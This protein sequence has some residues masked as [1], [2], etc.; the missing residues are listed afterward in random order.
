MDPAVASRK[1]INASN[2]YIWCSTERFAT[3]SCIQWLL[4][5]ASLQG[6]KN[7]W[8]GL[9][10][11]TADL[12][13]I[14][15]AVSDVAGHQQISAVQHHAAFFQ[16]CYSN[17]R[18]ARAALSRRSPM[19]LSNSRSRGPCCRVRLIIGPAGAHAS[20][21]HQCICVLLPCWPGPVICIPWMPF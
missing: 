2:I 6:Q 19:Q 11:L 10:N 16:K 4:L 20:S 9:T 8:S 5:H 14:P 7:L 17:A 18:D 21:N 3:L 1:R 13:H 15:T 12:R